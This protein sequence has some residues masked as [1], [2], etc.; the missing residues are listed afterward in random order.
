MLNRVRKSA[1][2]ASGVSRRERALV[3][4]LF[5][6][7]VM[8]AALAQDDELDALFE[9][10]PPAEPA[11][12]QSAE[13]TPAQEQPVAVIAV[14]EEALPTVAAPRGRQLEEIIVTATKRE[15]SLRDIPASI[16]AFLGDDLET[17]GAQGVDD[18]LR[19]SPGVSLSD[20][21]LLR[22]ITIRGISS[23]QLTSATTGVLYGDIPFNNPYVPRV[24]LDPNLFDMKTVEVLKGPQGTLFGGSA[25]NGAVRYSPWSQTMPAI[26]RCQRLQHL[27]PIML[28]MIA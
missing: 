17:Q 4:L 19:N 11:E 2:T 6:A 25:L 9:E 13:P 21:G 18:F 10:Q 24:Q 20:D 3:L 1:L 14:G 5:A 26:I 8:P 27:A 28:S 23:S 22:R 16:D 12:P 15:S 7:C